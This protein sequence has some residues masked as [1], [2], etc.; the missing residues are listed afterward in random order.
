M[1]QLFFTPQWFNGFDLVFEAIISIIALFIAAYS[2][3]VYKFS[4]EN[5]F[6][7][8]SVAFVTIALSFIIKILFYL[9]IA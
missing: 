6:A 5:K 9:L 4:Q 8:F 3:K 1:Y 7:Y 2:W